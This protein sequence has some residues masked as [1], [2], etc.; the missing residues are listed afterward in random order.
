VNQPAPRWWETAVVY[1]IYPRSFCDASG[2]GIGDLDGIRRH[3]DHLSWL[4]IDALWLSPFYCSPMADF[5]YDVADYC[6]VDP[7]FGTLTD[8]DRLLAEAHHRD[9]KV[10]IDWVPNHTS[11]QHPWFQAARSSP[12]DPKRGWYWWR[13][14]RPDEV[15]GWGPPGSEGRR[16]NNW[17]AAFPGV[18]LTEFPPAW[19]WDETTGQWYLHMFLAQQPDLNWTDPDVRSAMADVVHFWLA[20]GVDGFR[21]DAIQALGKDL[22]LPDLPPELAPVPISALNDQPSTHPLIAA[23]RT[24]LDRW[25]EPPPRLMVGEVFLPEP[26]QVVTYYGTPAGPKIASTS[27]IRWRQAAASQPV[28]SGLKLNARCTSGAAGVP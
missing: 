1:Q 28:N 15:G 14:D 22:A 23:V 3:L 12:A 24:E 6:D 9:I 4:G 21:V 5:G 17:R 11:D 27:S 19:T 26:S 8:F 20:R 2:D 13:D 25:P 16:P 10:L 7:L 18:G